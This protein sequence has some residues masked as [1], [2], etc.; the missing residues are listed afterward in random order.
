VLVLI[1]CGTPLLLL[2]LLLLLVTDG[3]KLEMAWTAGT[4][5]ETCATSTASELTLG[6]P[7]PLAAVGSAMA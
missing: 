7:V 1:R 2:L 4:L 6:L 3:T 5:L